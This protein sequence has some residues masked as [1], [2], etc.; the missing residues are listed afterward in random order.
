MY[1]SVVYSPQV[2]EL[3]GNRQ[4]IKEYIQAQGLVGIAIFVFFQVFQV[5]VAAV[6]GEIVQ[7]AGGYIYGTFWGT[8][9]LVVGVAIGSVIDFYIARWLGFGIVKTFISEK[10]LT[11]LYNLVRGPRS[12][13]VMFLLFLIPGLPKDILTYVAGLT[14]VPASRFLLIAIVARLPALIG[15][16]Y[17]GASFQQENTIVAIAVSGAAVVLFMLGVFFRAKIISWIRNEG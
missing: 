16:T 13:G 5:V 11:Q 7:I 12:H 3:F 4:E 1:L 15:S 10:R 17:I 6:P 8:I 2:V 14:P 9:Y